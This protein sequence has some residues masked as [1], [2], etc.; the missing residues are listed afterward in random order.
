MEGGANVL[1]EAIV[2][3]VPVLASRIEG[4]VGI[5]GV[6]YPGYFEVGDTRGLKEIILRAETDSA[7]LDELRSCCDRLAPLF[8]PAREEAEWKS[9]LDSLPLFPSRIE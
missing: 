4:N 8:D 1:S 5:L 3:R 6:D 7:F 9:L 2:N